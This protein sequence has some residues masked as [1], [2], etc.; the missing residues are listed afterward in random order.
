MVT[1]V[2]VG[3]R[4]FRGGSELFGQ[5]VE[6]GA[7]DTDPQARD[8]KERARGGQRSGRQMGSVWRRPE[9]SASC[10]QAEH[11]RAERLVSGPHG[12]VLAAGPN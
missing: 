11:A 3:A 2:G 4:G 8:G 12:W 7:D 6:A 5:V 1:E 9:E 10:Q